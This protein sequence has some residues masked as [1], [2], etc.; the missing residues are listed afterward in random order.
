MVRV[1]GMSYTL[2]PA[3]SFG[4]R[5]SNM[6]L[7]NGELLEASKNYMVAGWATVGEISRDRRFGKLSRII[8]ANQEVV[9]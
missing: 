5:I 8:C 6:R 9:R 7:G 3:N 2:E 4:K 1:L